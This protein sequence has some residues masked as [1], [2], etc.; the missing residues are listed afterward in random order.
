MAVNS[1][2][3]KDLEKTHNAT[4]RTGHTVE[5]A[6]KLAAAGV[7]HKVIALQLSEGSS[8]GTKYKSS[9][10]PTLVKIHQDNTRKV[11]INKDQYKALLKDQQMENARQ[12][13]KAAIK[14][15]TEVE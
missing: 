1:K 9:E 14:K 13:S 3:D 10:I 4:E 12:I 2:K 11:N 6:A 7:P 8:T 5:R 15:A